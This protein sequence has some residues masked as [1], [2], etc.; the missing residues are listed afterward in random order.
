M[1]VGGG[2]LLYW[3]RELALR[4]RR[5]D[6][7]LY[8][9]FPALKKLRVEGKATAESSYRKNVICFRISGAVLAAGGV[10]LSCGV[11]LVFFVVRF[12]I[13]GGFRFVD[14]AMLAVFLTLI[15]VLM[16]FSRDNRISTTTTNSNGSE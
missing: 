10:S 8:K 11:F 1:A 3:S 12:H 5:W 9:A 2:A 4:V 16:F 7:A 13:A 15:A 14:W 6:L